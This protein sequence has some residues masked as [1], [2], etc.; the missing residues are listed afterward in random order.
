[1]F[2]LPPRYS[3][4]TNLATVKNESLPLENHL[5]IADMETWR[6][7]VNAE[8]KSKTTVDRGTQTV[9]DTMECGVQTEPSTIDDLEE[10]SEVPLL[11][12]KGKRPL[13]SYRKRATA[14]A[15][16]IKKTVSTSLEKD[17]L[18]PR[19]ARHEEQTHSWN[20]FQR[21]TLTSFLLV[22]TLT[23]PFIDMLYP[24]TVV[25]STSQYLQSRSLYWYSYGVGDASF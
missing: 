10:D 19:R 11:R 18:R 21:S 13:P 7:T 2:G 9:N 6:D 15:S 5:K 4:T 25:S 24:F 17:S 22:S 14:V 8:T 16:I 23:T 3:G 20:P 12:P 1:M